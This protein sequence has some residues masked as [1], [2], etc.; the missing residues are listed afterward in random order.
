MTTK[1]QPLAGFLRAYEHA[2]R[3]VDRFA[4]ALLRGGHARKKLFDR[5]RS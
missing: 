2:H 1:S 3:D 4:I 5:E